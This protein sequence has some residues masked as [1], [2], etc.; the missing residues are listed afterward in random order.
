MVEERRP[1]TETAQQLHA[2][3]RALDGAKR[4]YMQDHIDH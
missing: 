3:V 2:V 4:T 1:C